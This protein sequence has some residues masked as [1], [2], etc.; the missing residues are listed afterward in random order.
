[1]ATR[2]I[3]RIATCFRT[4]L[5]RPGIGG[6]WNTD[7][8]VTHAIDFDRT[9]CGRQI[10]LRIAVGGPWECRNGSTRD[11]NCRQCLRLLGLAPSDD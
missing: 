6:D 9:V 8:A 1:M 2:I 3:T 5:G 4:K 11:V 7:T 10:G